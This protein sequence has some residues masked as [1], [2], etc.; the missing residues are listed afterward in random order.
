M[1]IPEHWAAAFINFVEEEGGDVED[2][3]EIL[4]VLSSW[5]KLLPGAVFGTS[6]AEKL[7]TL[8][9]A[10]MKQSFDSSGD[11]FTPAREAA[12]RLFVFMVRKDTVRHIDSVIE[13]TK[14]ILDKKHGVIAVFAECA[15]EPGEDFVSRIKEAVKQ[16]M[17]AARV[18]MTWKVN[19]ELLGG[20]RLKIGDEV[21]DVSVRLQLRQLEACLTGLAALPKWSDADGGN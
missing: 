13:K 6:D 8:V 12:A 4:K 9:R 15:F 16:R 19:P 10:G 11:V 7:E 18:D 1:F 17:R 2:G 3:I 14:S 21:I 20:Y 5:V